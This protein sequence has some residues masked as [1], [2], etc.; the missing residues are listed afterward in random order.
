MADAPHDV[1]IIGAGICGLLAATS[2]QNAGRT[3]QLVDKGRGVGGR[4]GTRR[5]AGGRADHGAQLIYGQHQALQPLLQGWQE[6]GLI[7]GTSGRW[8]PNFSDVAKINLP[9]FFGT[10]GMN[11][12]PKALAASLHVH[13][14]TRIT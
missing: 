6:A 8:F 11:S 7:Y 9:M 1:L 13:T 14:G 3:V 2:L 5:F 12:V 10:N 4:M